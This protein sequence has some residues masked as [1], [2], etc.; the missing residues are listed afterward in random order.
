MVDVICILVDIGAH[1]LLQV[2]LRDTARTA[3]LGL[4]V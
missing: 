1:L 3:G 4:L 2:L